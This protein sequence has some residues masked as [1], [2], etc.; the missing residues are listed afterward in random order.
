ML[1][2][3][4]DSGSAPPWSLKIVQTLAGENWDTHT[5]DV[6]P[7][8]VITMDGVRINIVTH[9]VALNLSSSLTIISLGLDMSSITITVVINTGISTLYLG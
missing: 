5:V 6:P 1:F 3:G 7:F 2:V 9:L 4:G 8:T